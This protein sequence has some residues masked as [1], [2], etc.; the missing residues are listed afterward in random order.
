MEA[1]DEDV[2]DFGSEGRIPPDFWEN[3]QG[4]GT[5]NNPVR[6]RIMGDVTSD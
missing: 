3:F 2:K 6:C 5:S 4:G 1:V